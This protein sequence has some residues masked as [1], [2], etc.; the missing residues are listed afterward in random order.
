[1]LT[2][3]CSVALTACWSLQH[4]DSSRY[5]LA[6]NAYTHYCARCNGQSSLLYPEGVDNHA[7]Q[8]QLPVMHRVARFAG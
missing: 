3:L 4:Q 5:V 2:Q 1:M 6:C 8:P 7:G